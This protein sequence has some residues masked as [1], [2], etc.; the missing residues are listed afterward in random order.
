MTFQDALALMVTQLSTGNIELSGDNY[1]VL[2]GDENIATHGAP[3]RIVIVPMSAQPEGVR[4]Q[5]VDANNPRAIASEKHLFM[6]ELWHAGVQGDVDTKGKDYIAVSNMKATFT[7]VMRDA[8]GTNFQLGP[9]EWSSI[10]GESLNEN[11]RRYNQQ[12]TLSQLTLDV[13]P[14][15]QPIEHTTFNSGISDPGDDFTDD[16]QL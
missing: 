7:R 16:A 6:A 3:P 15:S 14:L 10:R 13:T 8:F 2:V 1:E 5:R 9:G 4:M 12:F 11:G